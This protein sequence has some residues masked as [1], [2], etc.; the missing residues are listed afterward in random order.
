LKEAKG[1][2]PKNA[3]SSQQD[4]VQ[5][6]YS[7]RQKRIQL[8]D[9]KLENFRQKDFSDAATLKAASEAL[10]SEIQDLRK[11]VHAARVRDDLA[12]A[13]GARVE[14]QF[15]ESSAL[16][17]KLRRYLREQINGIKDASLPFDSGFRHDEEDL[18]KPG[19]EL[20]RREPQEDLKEEELR[21]QIKAKVDE[22]SG[23]PL[24]HLWNALVSQKPASEPKPIPT[25]PPDGQ[26]YENR[27]SKSE[28]AP[29]F[30][31]RVYGP[32]LDGNFTRADL[33]RVDP[34]AMTGL[35]NWEARFGRTDILPTKKERT[36][37]LANEPM[38][39]EFAER[40]RA[41]NAARV[42]KSRNRTK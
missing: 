28:N 29:A 40:W 23:Q 18:R 5:K 31:Q 7:R 10:H 9:E 26:L 2:L 14:R 17:S 16:H 22:L 8:L 36:D 30:I 24:A 38:S 6:A 13:F 39:D 15:R 11:E 25:E 35:K 37:K 4:E 32:W 12:P 1:L 33:R 42:R 21:A 20:L 19:E 41:L 3:A 34:G 27:P